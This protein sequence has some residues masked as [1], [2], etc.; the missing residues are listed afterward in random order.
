MRVLVVYFITIMLGML[1][2]TCKRT[3]NAYKLITSNYDI[4]FGLMLKPTFADD[5][6]N[7]LIYSNI[8]ISFITI[9]AIIRHFLTSKTNFENRK[10]DKIKR[11]FILTQLLILLLIL[12]RYLTFIFEQHPP[13]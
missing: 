11:R 13:F 5:H 6:L 3:N 9:G 8:G 7:F 4:P 12:F 1:F 10:S 2:F